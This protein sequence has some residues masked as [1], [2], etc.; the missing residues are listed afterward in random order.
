M[1]LYA[2]MGP[3]QTG[4]R[5]MEAGSAR[6]APPTV[7]QA[8]DFAAHDFSK[9]IQAIAEHQDKS[10]FVKLFEHFAPRVKSYLMRGGTNEEFADELAQ[11]TM[12]AIWNKAAN[13]DP[14]KA[15]ASTWIFT[16]A[17]NKKIDALRSRGQRYDVN[18]DEIETLTDNS[19]DSTENLIREDETF[20]IAEAIKKLP[21]EQAELIR[22]SFFDGKSHSE[23]AAEKNLPLGTV[24][25]RMRLALERLRKEQNVR[26]LW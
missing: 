10:S 11:E 6:I 8:E 24:K 12:L 22:L 9:M 26:D 2:S 16:I 19:V 7:T 5:G 20:A 25:S 1:L 23:I 17:R 13:F 4:M 3:K 21:E 15:G 14:K 18:I